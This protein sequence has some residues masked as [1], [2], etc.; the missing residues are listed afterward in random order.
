MVAEASLKPR[1]VKAMLDL[2]R[3][4]RRE[5][6][7]VVH[8]H[9]AKAGF[10][11]RLAARLAGVPVVVHSFHGHILHGYYGPAKSWLLRRME[12][13][14]AC[15]SDR[16][17]AVS[18]QVKRDLVAYGVAPPEKITVIPLG[19]DL[20]PFLQA[21][22]HRHEFRRE[23]GLDGDV[24]LVGIVGRIFP[25]KNHRL[26][27]D[28]AARVAAREPAARFVIVGDG[29][30]RPEMERHARE[31]GIADRVSFTGWR[32]DLPRIYADLDVLVVSSDN[33]GTPVSAIEAM[34]TG[35]PVVGTRVGGLP[36]LIA[37]GET[38]YLVPP[39]DPE[40]LAAGILRL[41]Q[42]PPDARRIAARAQQSV[43]TRFS[44]ERLVAD[45][46]MLY[47]ELLSKAGLP[48]ARPQR[49]LDL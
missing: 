10:L 49:P 21:R 26:F 33:E 27:L 16:L 14:L 45:M 22:A 24:L 3:L 5:R 48:G 39:K 46:E 20:D 29:V 12:Q 40:A 15:A 47:S 44:V 32:R 43:R 13:A 28:A 7:H 23:L 6:P 42:N 37:E 11:G 8:T 17:I 25:I 19:F 35:C 41:L 31:L 2:Y 30:L 4:M 38:G 18:E 36:D 9:T 34:A 1:D